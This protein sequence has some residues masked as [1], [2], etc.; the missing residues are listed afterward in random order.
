MVLS[1]NG[2]NYLPAICANVFE[3]LGDGRVGDAL[4]ATEREL[5]VARAAGFSAVRFFLHEALHFSRGAAFLDDVSRF[6]EVFERHG[7]DVILVLFDACWRPDLE[8]AEPID[9]VH[10]SAMPP[11]GVSL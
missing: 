4:L 2:A 3:C 10:N 6:L 7:V 8:G 11:P 5:R 9:G 1:T